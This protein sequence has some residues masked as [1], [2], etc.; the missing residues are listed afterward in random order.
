[1]LR[2]G[3]CGRLARGR[4]VGNPVCAGV[5]GPALL[6]MLDLDPAFVRLGGPQR[7]SENGPGR[8]QG[9]GFGR[10]SPNG[11]GGMNWLGA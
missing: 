10:L 1:M 8:R 11:S 7:D 5:E 6:I 2:D 9:Q 4:E 3:P